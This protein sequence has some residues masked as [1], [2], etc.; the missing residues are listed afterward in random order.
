MPQKRKE[1]IIFFVRINQTTNGTHRSTNSTSTGDSRCW[2]PAYEHRSSCSSY[3]A[4]GSQGVWNKCTTRI[5]NSSTHI[6]SDI[7][8]DWVVA[9]RNRATTKHFCLRT[10]HFLDPVNVWKHIVQGVHPC[11]SNLTASNEVRLNLNEKSTRRKLVTFSFEY[12]VQ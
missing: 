5:A 3:K 11:K 10:S 4:S 7:R 6:S 2:C 9:I 8:H 1:R 12:L